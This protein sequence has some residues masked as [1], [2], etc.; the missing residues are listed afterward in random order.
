MRK[1][2]NKNKFKKRKRKKIIDAYGIFVT[3]ILEIV[4]MKSI[5]V[6]GAGGGA[7]ATK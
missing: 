6:G 5:Y 7:E 4:L 3:L 1:I 2:P